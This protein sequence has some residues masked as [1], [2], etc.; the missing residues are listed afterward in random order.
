[1]RIN[2]LSNDVGWLLD[3]ER[4]VWRTRDAG[5]SWTCLDA[6]DPAAI[7]MG[8]VNASRGWLRSFGKVL[9]TSDAGDHWSEL[10]LPPELAGQ[11]VGAVWAESESHIWIAVSTWQLNQGAARDAPYP[12]VA[13]GQEVLQAAVFFSPDTGKTWIRQRLP[14]RAPY[15]LASLQFFSSNVGF[16][17]GDAGI[18]YTSDGGRT[19]HSGVFP[20]SCVSAN[21][22]EQDSQ[23]D[24]GV[25]A[26]VT[27]KEAWVGYKHGGLLHTTDGGQ[28]WCE[29]GAAA[30][31]KRPWGF[32][33]LKFTSSLAG[34]AVTT[35]HKLQR[36]IDGGLHWMPVDVGGI[37][38]YLQPGRARSWLL[39]DKAILGN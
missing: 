12:S 2:F 25:L 33:A 15:T 21:F 32:S 27:E 13:R 11:T 36:S 18:L 19:W 28:H 39:T 34:W 17:L 16:G 8:F 24:P 4:N 9:W 1:V 30:N 7:D 14:S 37:V 20:E 31:S 29:L 35:D 5:L 22:L 6:P 26:A 38:L 3:S 23:F 10:S